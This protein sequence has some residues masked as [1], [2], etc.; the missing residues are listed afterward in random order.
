MSGLGKSTGGADYPPPPTWAPANSSHVDAEVLD[1][2]VPRRGGAQ[3]SHHRRTMLKPGKCCD[4]QASRWPRA[5]PHG[6]KAF[7]QEFSTAL[8]RPGWKMA[9]A[10]A[11][12]LPKCTDQQTSNL[13][14]CLCSCLLKTT[15]T[16]LLLAFQ[17]LRYRNTNLSLPARRT[18]GCGRCSSSSLTAI[19]N[20]RKKQRKHAGSKGARV[21]ADLS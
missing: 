1:V 20:T 11:F 6:N 18:T 10:L 5:D 7:R 14:P 15:L 16:T 21:Q 12:L 3:P 8:H 19:A 17:D 4:S 9:A 2:A 13:M